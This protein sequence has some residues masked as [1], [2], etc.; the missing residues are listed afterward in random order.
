PD[1]AQIPL[2]Q[3]AT[4]SYV[5]GPQVIKSEDTFLV[6]YVLFDKKSEFAEVDVVE[7][8]RAYLE[9]QRQKG[10]LQL[11]PGVSYTFAGTYENQVRSEKKLKVVLPLA[12]GIIFLI[13]YMQFRRVTTSLLVFSGIFVAWAGGFIFIWLYSQSWFL[14]FS[15]FGTNMQN[16]FQV[17]PFNLSVAVW[18]GFLA[19]FGVTTDD[20]VIMGT[21]LDEVFS[22]KKPNTVADIRTNVIEAGLRRIRPA[23]MTEATTIL[24][25]IPVLTSTGRGS[26]IM[27]PMAIPSFGGMVIE[28][29]SMLIVPVLYCAIKEFQLRFS[30]LTG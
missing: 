11:P 22:A 30:D 14:N 7:Q 12:L 24:S 8:A 4:I 3:L 18:V 26:E 6:G 2:T 27:L 25:L 28:T 16:L 1:G 13:L 9:E 20:G 29:I 10:L 15:I 17:H 21:Y 5:R 19:L 23:I